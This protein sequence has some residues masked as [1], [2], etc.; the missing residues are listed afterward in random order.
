MSSKAATETEPLLGRTRSL[1]SHLS[2]TS[3][4]KGW[5]KWLSYTTIAPKY[6]WVPLLGCAIIFINEAEY[7]IKQVA[8]LRAIEAMYCYKFYLE[9]DSPLADLGKHIPERLCKDDSIQKQLAKTAGLI[10]FV[11][12]LCALIGAIP[13]GYVADRYGRKAVLILHKVNVVITCLTFVALCEVIDFEAL[14]GL[15]I[16]RRPWISESPNL[17]AISEWYPGTRWW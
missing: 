1:D 9:R 2:T 8:T 10:M 15:L 4:P 12:M 16:I 6:R 5:T 13:L 7:F 17:V 14:H 3:I 11:R